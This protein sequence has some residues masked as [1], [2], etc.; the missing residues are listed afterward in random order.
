MPNTSSEPAV[1]CQILLR[2]FW[3]YC[4]SPLR[5]DDSPF[6]VSGVF[7]H[8]T[9][10]AMAMRWR[11][12]DLW[13]VAVIFAGVLFLVLMTLVTVSVADAHGGVSG[14]ASTGTV[15]V[16]AT[17]TEDATVT[18][19]NK[20]K[21][22][23]E[24]KQL[25]EQNKP[26]PLG[27][28]RTN[29]AILFSTLAVVFGGL[30]GLWR[31]R[32]D[33]QDA[34]DKELK[35]RR[36]AQDKELEDRKAEREKRVEERFQSAVTGLGDEKE[37]ARIGAAIL[38]K[39]FLRLGY[40]QFYTQIFQLVAA[41][42][43]LPRTPN[44]PEDPAAPLP[45]TAL[46]HALMMTFMEAFPLARDQ[47]KKNVRTKL[48]DNEYKVRS[49]HPAPVTISSAEI[50]SLNAVGI[51]L[52]NGF[53]WYADLKQAWMAQASLRKTDLTGADLSEANLYAA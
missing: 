2:F 13:K 41:N 28:L 46:R 23:Q 33:R 22:A 16:Q 35:D 6:R 21:L 43:R 1:F 48:A 15:T 4:A 9:A 5:A 12:R 34:Q 19:L 38:L 40:E 8:R 31:W 42:L 14:A 32:V 11:K 51:R 53:F 20:E 27:W 3:S 7:N 25:Q 49:T 36:D 52:D 39:T 26:D 18:A 30:F 17:P 29:V 24:V 45:L 44:P 50:H 47:E 10:E 37:G